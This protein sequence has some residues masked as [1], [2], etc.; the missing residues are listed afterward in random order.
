MK[1]FVSFAML[2]VILCSSQ[3]VYANKP[4]VLSEAYRSLGDLVDEKLSYRIS[5]LWFRKIARGEMSLQVGEKPGTYLATLKAETKGLAAFFTRDRVETF[6]TLMEEG[7]GGMLRPL[8]QTSDTHKGKSE[9]VDTRQTIYSYDYAARKVGYSKTV[10][11]TKEMDIEMPM[12]ENG[13]L[14]DFLTAFYNM[15]LGRFG[16]ADPGRDIVLTAFS[17]KGPEELII[18]RVVGKI[19]Q[20]LGFDDNVLLCRVILDPETFKTKGKVIYVGFDD[21]WRAQRVIIPNV[22]GFGDVIAVLF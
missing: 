12:P 2:M 5:F 13:P 6:T 17:R 1:F 16:A 10:N 7:P 4:A 3:M 15:R 9:D 11:G 8:L 22:I 20:D 14:Y 21:H 18:T 19:Q